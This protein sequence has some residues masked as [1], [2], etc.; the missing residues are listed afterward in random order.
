M[1]IIDRIQATLPGAS[2][3]ERTRKRVPRGYDPH[4]PRATLLLADSLHVSGQD[5][6]PATVTTSEFA[7]WV[8]DRLES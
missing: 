5:P 4:H 2:L 7:S 3:S 8:V 1:A 6:T